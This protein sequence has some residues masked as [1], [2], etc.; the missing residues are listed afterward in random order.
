VCVGVTNTVP[1][2]YDLNERLEDFENYNFF[3]EVLNMPLKE[4]IRLG[5]TN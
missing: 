5:S 1:S 2:S 3:F 4:D